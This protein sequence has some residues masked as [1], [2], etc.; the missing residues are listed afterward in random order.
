MIQERKRIK[1]RYTEMQEMN[2]FY[3]KYCK[4]YFRTKRHSCM[5]DPAF[6]SCSTCKNRTFKNHYDEDY[7]IDKEYA[8]CRFFDKFCSSLKWN[9]HEIERC[10]KTLPIQSHSFIIDCSAWEKE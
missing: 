9:E 10:G 8:F 2:V 3:C 4:K 6:K 5:K 1:G 7:S